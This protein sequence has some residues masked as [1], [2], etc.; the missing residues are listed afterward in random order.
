MKGKVESDIYTNSQTIV[1]ISHNTF[2]RTEHLRIKRFEVLAMVEMESAGVES[3]VQLGV[4]V[5][6][7][8]LG[9]GVSRLSRAVRQAGS[10]GRLA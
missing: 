7:A 3:S 10:P 4:R 6:V 8:R 1:S 5:A 9:V 2:D